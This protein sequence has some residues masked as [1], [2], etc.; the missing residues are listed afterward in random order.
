MEILT[1]LTIKPNIVLS[2]DYYNDQPVICLSFK[3][4]QQ[5][6]N[7][8]KKVTTAVWSASRRYWYLEQAD[9][10]LNSFLSNLETL[11]TFII[12]H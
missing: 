9:L 3:Y 12:L 8:L 5:V 2:N 6:I 1:D 7:R 4:N 11:L 10:K